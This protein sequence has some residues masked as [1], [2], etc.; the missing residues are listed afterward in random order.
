MEIRTA[1]PDDAPVIREIYRPYVEST[2][3]TFE[4]ETPSE[5][6]LRRRIGATLSS[7]PYLVATESGKIMGYAYAGPFKEREAYRWAVELS[8]YVRDDARGKGTGSLLYGELFP[9]LLRM[10][11]TNVN[12]CISY[13]DSGSV[14]FHEKLGFH[15]VA[16]FT[17][18]GYK[19]GS[20]RDMV[21]MEKCIAEHPVP[22]LPFVPFREL[23]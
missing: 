7:Y 5:E 3:I 15:T 13:P 14:A 9:I 19:F 10:H 20:W 6:E 17:K 2:V 23:S 1:T 21:W 22:P 11:V 8:V 12:A 18:C 16:H 4:Y